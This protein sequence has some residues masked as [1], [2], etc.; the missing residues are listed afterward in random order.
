MNK[1]NVKTYIKS[2]VDLSTELGY[3]VT[4]ELWIKRKKYD[5]VIDS[6]TVRIT[7][8]RKSLLMTIQEDEDFAFTDLLF[9]S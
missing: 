8:A 4:Q 2:A 7:G 5:F 1:L 3:P 6:K 9:E